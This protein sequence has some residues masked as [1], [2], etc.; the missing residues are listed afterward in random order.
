MRAYYQPWLEGMPEEFEEA[1]FL[2][3]QPITVAYRYGQKKE[4]DGPGC[5]EG[6]KAMVR[7]HDMDYIKYLSFA[8]AVHARYCLLHV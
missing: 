8:T 4:I 1:F 7:N 5:A 2:E 3:T 6:M